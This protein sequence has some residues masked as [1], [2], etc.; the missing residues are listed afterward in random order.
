MFIGFG[1]APHIY[2]DKLVE[3]TDVAEYLGKRYGGWMNLA[4]IYGKRGTKN[5]IGLPFGGSTGPIDVPEIGGQRGRLHRIPNDHA[6]FLDLCQKLKTAGKPF[7]IALGHAVGDG[8]G[9]AKWLIWSHGGYLVDEKGKVAINCKETSRAEIPK[10][11][12]QT[13]LPG[14][15]T[16]NDVGNNQAYAAANADDVQWRLAVLRAEDRP[17]D[18][19]DGRG[20]R[21]PA[22]ATWRPRQSPMAGLINAMLFKHSSTPCGQ[23]LHQFMMEHEQY[24]PWL[25]AAWAIGPSAEGLQASAVWTTTR[26]SD[27]RERWMPS[28]RTAT[29]ARSPRRPARRRRLQMVHMFAAVASGASTPE[30]AARAA[31]RPAVATSA[32]EPGRRAFPRERRRP[33][34]NELCP[35]PPTGLA[36]DPPGA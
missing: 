21:A 9:F 5:W 34:G 19:G 17:G 31:E 25:T 28:S 11:L 24:G 1:D 32:A 35:S 16:W 23:G 12:Y 26:R 3:L 7:G 22:A 6:S 18:Q 33:S 36:P 15:L 10:E 27:L 29:R 14:T 30:A 13:L 8:N 20:Q 4:Q 2:V